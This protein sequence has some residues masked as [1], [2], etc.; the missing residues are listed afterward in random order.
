MSLDSW[1]HN[2]CPSPISILWT[3]TNQWCPHQCSDQWAQMHIFLWA[4]SLWCCCAVPSY[5]NYTPGL[6]QAFVQKNVGLVAHYVW[7]GTDIRQLVLHLT[8]TGHLGDH[9]RDMKPRPKLAGIWMVSKAREDGLKGKVTGK[10]CLASMSNWGESFLSRRRTCKD[11]KVMTFSQLTGKNHLTKL[12]CAYRCVC[13]NT[14][15]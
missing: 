4:F 7:T 11:K 5:L 10:M 13:A 12:I 1:R 6:R 3:R 14:L 8:L 9:T 2:F 15:C